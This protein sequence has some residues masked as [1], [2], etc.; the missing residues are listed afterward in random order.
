MATAVTL[1][2][3]IANLASDVRLRPVGRGKES[4]MEH[5]TARELLVRWSIRSWF[6]AQTLAIVHLRDLYARSLA[7]ESPYQMPQL[8]RI[9]LQNALFEPSPLARKRVAPLV[10]RIDNFRPAIEPSRWL[11]DDIAGPSHAIE[12]PDAF[13]E[14]LIELNA[15]DPRPLC[16]RLD[17][18]RTDSILRTASKTEALYRAAEL[19][20]AGES[21]PWAQISFEPENVFLSLEFPPE[22]E[23]LEYKATFRADSRS[24]QKN[25]H[26]QLA[27]LKTI[28]AFL[29]GVGGTLICGIDDARNVIGLDA[30]FALIKAADKPDFFVQIVHEAI[31]QHLSP[32]THG[33][34]TVDL[35]RVEQ[36]M[37]AVI[38]V[39][40]SSETVWLNGVHY[41][42]DGNRTV[43][44]VSDP[45]VS[46]PR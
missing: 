3:L 19:V 29:N 12:I 31:K 9:L 46:E 7:P 37:V 20:L 44:L 6:I 35:V 45:A 28:A 38:S 32:W 2:A 41:I 15:P 34:F 26:Q 30:D 33:L 40:P 14:T 4:A 11:D 36:S 5:A 25:P 22:G 24:G 43:K 42:R 13:W 18:A 27:C 17:R 16:P 1:S 10:G 39:Q 8:L 21:E 23:I